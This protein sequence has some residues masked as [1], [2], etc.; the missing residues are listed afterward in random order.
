MRLLVQELKKIWRPGAAAALVLFGALLYSLSA[1]FAVRY[2]PNGPQAQHDFEA[3]LNWHGRFGSSLDVDEIEQ[4]AREAEDA[5]AEAERAIAE[6]PA[7]REAGIATKEELDAFAVDVAAREQ[8]ARAA[9]V[10]PGAELALDRELLDSMLGLPAYARAANAEIGAQGLTGY[11]DTLANHVAEAA[12][13]TTVAQERLRALGEG[14]QGY[15]SDMWLQNVE[16]YLSALAVWLMIAPVFVAAPAAARDRLCRVRATQ[17]TSRTGRRLFATQLAAVVCSVASVLVASVAAWALPFAQTGVFALADVRMAGGLNVY[18]CWW[19]MT[20]GAYVA[21]RVLL[22]MALGLG[23]GVAAWLLART[24]AGY[25]GM[26]LRLV[27]WCVCWGWLVAP[28]LFDHALCVR[29]APEGIGRAVAALPVPGAEVVFVMIAL[30]LVAF[31][32]AMAAVRQHRGELA[33]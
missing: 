19:D 1:S 15:L 33:E 27:P 13:M 14:E 11:A 7:A 10:E 16:M 8:E 30:V 23:S 24:S 4:I 2:F 22:M 6:M 29:L 17:W 20:F 18:C 9:G 12:D 3:A 31:W 28:G 32:C 25:V 21:A 26:L 5:W